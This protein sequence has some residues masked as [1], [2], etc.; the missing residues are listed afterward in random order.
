MLITAESVGSRS[1]LQATT[2][3]QRM[4]QNGISVVRTRNHEVKTD[5]DQKFNI[6]PNLPDRDFMEGGP[7]HKW[8]RDIS[9]IWTRDGWM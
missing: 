8:A 9:Y 3:G 7:N 1:S 4:R 2:A 6:A 5:T